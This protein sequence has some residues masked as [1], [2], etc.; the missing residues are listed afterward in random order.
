MPRTRSLKEAELTPALRARRA[1]AF[2]AARR[3]H[4]C[5]TFCVTWTCAILALCFFDSRGAFFRPGNH[6]YDD[7]RAHSIVVANEAPTPVGLTAEDPVRA[8]LE[9]VFGQASSSRFTVKYSRRED[10]AAFFTLSE[11]GQGRI[12]HIQADGPLS[13]CS[14]VHHYCLHHGLCTV[15]WGVKAKPRLP[16][17]V[18]LPSAEVSRTRVLKYGYYLNVCTPSY[19]MAWWSWEQWQQGSVRQFE[20]MA[21]RHG[22]TKRGPRG[23]S[24]FTWQEL[25]WMALH[26]INLPLIITGREYVMLQLFLEFGMAEADILAFFTGS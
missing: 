19:T 1:A 21:L 20:V 11:A 3:V 13:A 8:L 24:W 18:S 7:A 2:N 6:V 9:R 26:G 17:I 15:T 14:G 22:R 4:P 12:L 16:A 23:V 10:S 25:D 5:Y